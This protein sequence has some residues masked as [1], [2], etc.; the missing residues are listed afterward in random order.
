MKIQIEVPNEMIE[1]FEETAGRYGV[2]VED[3]IELMF[4]VMFELYREGI[5]LDISISALG[6]ILDERIAEYC[7][8]VEE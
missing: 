2:S 3:L 5:S 7:E 8:V 1:I 4:R 6:N